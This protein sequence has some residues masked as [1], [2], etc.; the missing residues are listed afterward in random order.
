MPSSPEIIHRLTIRR[1]TYEKLA[2]LFDMNNK[3]AV[4]FNS[5]AILK[6]STALID[7]NETDVAYLKQQGVNLNA[8]LPDGHKLAD[9]LVKKGCL[10]PKMIDC[11]HKGGYCFNL[12]NGL[13]EHCGYYV[14]ESPTGV[15]W[16][17]VAALKGKGVDFFEENRFHVCPV[18]NFERAYEF[19]P[20]RLIPLFQTREGWI[21]LQ[22]G[23]VTQGE[24][25]R[26]FEERI[27]E[28]K[29]ADNAHLG[30]NEM[31]ERILL[32][33][34]LAKNAFKSYRQMQDAEKKQPPMALHPIWQRV[35][36]Q[37]KEQCRG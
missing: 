27:A 14:C 19:Y 9:S 34:A 4:L 26:L 1:K 10:S 30:T 36:G 28:I 33:Q 16:E 5:G 3:E 7:Y 18:M 23:F 29:P 31:A 2:S 35:I 17:T 15:S 24:I 20:E 12:P 11:L 8:L 6:E 21:K 22:S 37:G 13:D 25:K 32:A